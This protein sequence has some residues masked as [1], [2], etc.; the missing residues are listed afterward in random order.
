MDA[1]AVQIHYL[2]GHYV[3]SAK[4]KNSITMY[5][6]LRNSSR[7]QA[8]QQQLTN[9]YGTISSMQTKYVVAQTQGST[10][11]C[12][13]FAAANANNLMKKILLST[14]R[15]LQSSIRRYLNCVWKVLL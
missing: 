2:Q 3:V 8:L 5:D 11:D 9:M 6:S 12:G 14:I 10:L 7:V 13:A 15:Y 4:N 1:D